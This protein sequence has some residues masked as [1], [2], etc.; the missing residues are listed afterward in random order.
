MRSRPTVVEVAKHAGVGLG[1]ASRVING[2]S[3]VSAEAVSA[4]NAAIKEIGYVLPAPGRRRG[5]RSADAAKR[6]DDRAILLLLGHRDFSW[7]VNYCPVYAEVLLALASAMGDLKADLVIRHAPRYADVPAALNGIDISGAILFGD[8]LLD[9]PVPDELKRLPKVWLMGATP[10]GVACDHVVPDHF[11]VGKLAGEY[12]IGRGHRHCAFISA[13][14]FQDRPSIFTQ[15]TR[16]PAFSGMI[17]SSGGTCHPLI[18]AHVMD[19]KGLHIDESALCRL[20]D[21]FMSLTP[22]PTG[23]YLTDDIL[24]SSVYRLLLER[25]VG[26]GTDVEI[27]VTNNSVPSVRGLLPTPGIIDIR[28]PYLGHRAARQLI[29]RRANPDAPAERIAVVPALIAPAAQH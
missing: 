20:L 19:L 29:W 21:E 16:M 22:R 18:D 14:A 10:P 28:G 17:E 9:G 4:V 24:A 8:S 23:L 3:H 12:M 11:A 7:Y 1:T 26:I 15:A 2:K 27:L 25:G 13:H 6:Q 5:L